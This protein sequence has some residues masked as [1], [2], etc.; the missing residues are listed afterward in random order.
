MTAWD[1]I[2]NGNSDPNQLSH[3]WEIRKLIILME[4]TIV[5][6]D[7]GENFHCTWRERKLALKGLKGE[8][9]WTQI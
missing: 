2:A 5:N 7:N 4:K 9:I 3:S 8:T 1:L 6:G